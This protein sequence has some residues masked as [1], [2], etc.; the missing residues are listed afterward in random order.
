MTQAAATKIKVDRT[1]QRTIVE[2]ADPE[3]KNV[4]DDE[5]IDQLHAVLDASDERALLVLRGRGEGFSAGRPHSSGG[6][7]GGPEAARKA[8]NEVVRLN[9]RLA[10][11]KAPTLALV[12]GFAHGAA[13]GMIQQCDIALAEHGTVM[14][15]PEITYQLPPGLVASYL[16]RCVSE[17]AARYLVMSGRQVD[18]D[19]ALEMGLIS[20][21]VEP[22]A[23]GRAGNAL[24][25]HL[26]ER[27]EAEIWLK[28]TLTTFTPWSGDLA[29]LMQDGVQT[30]FAWAGRNKK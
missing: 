9:L 18:A 21:V 25:D 10:R 4:L 20:E 13:L 17:K 14:S 7:S 15:F 16:R 12:H 26:C 3:H 19:R 22:G 5:M 1:G 27:L 2:L 23:L 28:E 24:I 30:V 8:L 11:W 29:G 6:H